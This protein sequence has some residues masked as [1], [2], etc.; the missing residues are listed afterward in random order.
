VTPSVAIHVVMA[1]MMIIGCA[2]A[3]IA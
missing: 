1:M 3:A 2:P